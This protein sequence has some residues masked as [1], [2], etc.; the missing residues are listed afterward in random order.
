MLELLY[1]GRFD[2]LARPGMNAQPRI[3]N[4]AEVEAALQEL[5]AREHKR[6]AVSNSDIDQRKS[7]ARD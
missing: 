1:I 3:P 2:Y 5:K 6:E 4:D 7:S